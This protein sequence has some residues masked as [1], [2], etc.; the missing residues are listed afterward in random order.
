MTRFL[1]SWSD[2][3]CSWLHKMEPVITSAQR[4]REAGSSALDEDLWEAYYLNIC[5]I[6][7][8]NWCTNYNTIYTKHIINRWYITK[9]LSVIAIWLFLH[10]LI[11]FNEILVN[12]NNEMV[13]ISGH[14]HICPFLLG[15]SIFQL[16]WT[17]I[18][19]ST[20]VLC[21]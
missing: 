4:A 13:K 7:S 6:S 16:N 2:S 9:L 20:I 19:H 1:N 18:K 3:S 21:N 17:V 5:I 8:N 12:N 10:L 14:Q 11:T 15:W